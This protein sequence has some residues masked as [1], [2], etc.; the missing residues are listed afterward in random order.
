MDNRIRPVLAPLRNPFAV[1]CTCLLLLLAAT[2]LVHCRVSVA[3]DTA[4]AA[5]Q[6]TSG[7]QP[8]QSANKD[9]KPESM[10]GKW[11]RLHRDEKGQPVAM[12]TAVVRY[13]PQNAQSSQI[14]VDLVGAVHVGDQ[15]YYDTLNKRFEQYD[16]LLYELVAA[17]GTVVEKGRGTSNV[18]PVGAI[19]NGLK[20]FLKLEHQLEQIDYTCENFV[21]A[22]MSPD[23]FA[24]SMKD[25]GE[26]F[27]QMYFR[28]VGQEIARQSQQQAEGKSTDFGLFAAFFSSDRERRLK[29]ALAEQFEDMEG[30]L[31]SFGGPEGSTII[32]ERNRVAMDVLNEQL[33]EGK[34][35]LAIFYGAGHLSDMDKRLRERFKLKPVDQTWIDAW[36]LRP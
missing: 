4:P 34:K 29:V 18:H 3:D 32:T 12:Q 19:Q 1:G 23:E 27:L 6:K 9:E 11:I 31:G 25:R 20:S 17:D 21:H 26:S 22:D 35:K 13:I 10:P 2:L 5:Q 7:P 14:E 16:A 30:L 15:A 8:S 33:K 36:D 24:Q 28:L